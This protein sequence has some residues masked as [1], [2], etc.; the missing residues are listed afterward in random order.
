MPG[1]YYDYY[2]PRA[3]EL[4]GQ[5]IVVPLIDFDVKSLYASEPKSSFKLRLNRIEVVTRKA[6]H[7]VPIF[8]LK[9]TY[10]RCNYSL[11]GQGGPAVDTVQSSDHGDITD[12]GDGALVSED[13]V[14]DPLIYD[15]VLPSS[16]E[17]DALAISAAP[18]RGGIHIARTHPAKFLWDQM[19]E[20][21]QL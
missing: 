14:Y 3:G 4:S 11:D 12:T 13:V 15:Y 21:H 9:A 2:T 8:P 5:Y 1:V 6:N 10:N 16:K 7:V 17:V 19:P 18:G 20:F